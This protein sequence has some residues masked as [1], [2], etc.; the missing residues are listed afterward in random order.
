MDIKEYEKFVEST[1]VYP[2]KGDLGGLIYTAL[3]LCGESGE[4]AEKVKKLLRD[5]DGNLTPEKRLEMLK[6]LSD[7]AWYLTRMSAELGSSL[8]EVFKINM[9]KLLSRKARGVLQGEGDNR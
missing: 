6:E 8:E 2:A 3:G 7:V 1:S 5:S 4:V 9:E